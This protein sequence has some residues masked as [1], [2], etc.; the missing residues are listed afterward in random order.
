MKLQQSTST[1]FEYK[2]RINNRIRLGEWDSIAEYLSANSELIK[3][4]VKRKW[5]ESKDSPEVEIETEK[6]FPRKE[7]E[8]IKPMAGHYYTWC[9]TV[10]P[11][12]DGVNVNFNLHHSPLAKLI[13]I[14]HSLHQN[15]HCCCF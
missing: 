13:A 14:H 10:E 4:V 15:F 6:E 9:K 3:K 11:K 12:K 1:C 8:S 7:I 5:R 2:H